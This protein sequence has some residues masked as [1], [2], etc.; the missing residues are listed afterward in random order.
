MAR[1]ASARRCTGRTII[2]GSHQVKAM[3]SSSASAPTPT[4][5]AT[6]RRAAALAER[7]A[8]SMLAWF[9]RSTRSVA[10]L[11]RVKRGRSSR[12]YASERAGPWGAVSA[13][14]TEAT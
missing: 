8:D 13:R 14:S 6:P 1:A 11:S 12:K 2:R 3:R 5:S 9:I 10:S 4:V 7:S